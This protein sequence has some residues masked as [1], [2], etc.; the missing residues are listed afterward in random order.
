MRGRETDV[1]EFWEME[2]RLWLEGVLA[3]E[4]L[5][6]AR[7][8]MVFAPMGI[9]QRDSIVKSLRDAPRW[10]SV[11]FADQAEILGEHVAMLA[12]R[13]E[14]SREHTEPYNALCTSTY[15]R[16]GREWHLT[17][18]QQTARPIRPIRGQASNNQGRYTTHSF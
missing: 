3:Y 10:S 6:A 11:I 15:I 8:I 12:Y 7:C 9:M 18:H 4:N 13:A 16:E 2:R 1:T 17:Q 14:A 5:M